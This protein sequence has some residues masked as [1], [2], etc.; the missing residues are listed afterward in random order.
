MKVKLT[1]SRSGPDGAF[2]VG[3]EIDVADDEAKR[4]MEAGQAIP[5]RGPKV[6]RAVPS[7][8]KAEKAAK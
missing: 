3:D 8:A 1:V 5:V 7:R 4:M 6:E 2:N